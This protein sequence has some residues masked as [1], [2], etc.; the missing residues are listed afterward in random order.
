MA[1]QAALA[2]RGS[3]AVPLL[4]LSSTSAVRSA[5]TAGAGPAVLSSL[6]VH[7]DLAAGRLVEV[8]VDGL[9][10]GRILRAVWPRGQA[11]T[12]PARDLLVTAA[13]PAASVQEAVATAL[14][15]Q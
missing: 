14:D 4:E 10:L 9:D 7:Q 12:G 15:R 13:R 11:P 2:G 5:V 8:R 1:L 3:L 6:A